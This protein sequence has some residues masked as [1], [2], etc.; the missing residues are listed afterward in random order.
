MQLPYSRMSLIEHA[1]SACID[2]ESKL[3]SSMSEK[4]V[5]FGSIPPAK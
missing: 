5:L 3:F 4:S 2:V 1:C